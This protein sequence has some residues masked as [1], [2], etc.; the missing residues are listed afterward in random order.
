MFWIIATPCKGGF[1]F[2]GDMGVVFS[3]FKDV[4]D[5]KKT[6]GDRHAS[7][8]FF[9]GYGLVSGGKYLGGRAK[10]LGL[11]FA[12][13]GG[14]YK[15]HA[16]WNLECVLGLYLTPS[17]LFFIAPGI[18]IS[19]NSNGNQGWLLD[20]G[21]IL[22]IGSRTLITGHL[23]WQI[24]GTFLHHPNVFKADGD[25]KHDKHALRFYVGFG[26]NF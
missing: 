23:F 7:M 12:H 17:N 22:S 6:L 14:V 16:F 4:T 10:I 20:Y 8:N 21:W 25:E 2:G 19:S 1:Y 9:G 18:E 3:Q 11:D 26:Y 5:A 13:P 15:T 24:E